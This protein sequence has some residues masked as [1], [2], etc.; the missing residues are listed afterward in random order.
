MRAEHTVARAGEAADEYERVLFYNFTCSMLAVYRI[1]I[2]QFHEI[3]E[4]FWHC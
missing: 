1:H 3:Y 4:L 2:A